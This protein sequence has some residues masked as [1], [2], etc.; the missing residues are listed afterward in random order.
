[1]ASRAAT[2]SAQKLRKGAGMNNEDLARSG[3]GSGGL[4]S[5]GGSRDGGASS[6]GSHSG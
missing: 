1:M 2:V 3:G 6:G 5:S 4:A